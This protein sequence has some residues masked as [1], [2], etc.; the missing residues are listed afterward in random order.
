MKWLEG[1]DNFKAEQHVPIESGEA[2]SHC[3]NWSGNLWHSGRRVWYH[4]YRKISIIL[5]LEESAVHEERFTSTERMHH[6]RLV[7]VWKLYT[8]PSV[9]SAGKIPGAIRQSVLLRIWPAGIVMSVRNHCDTFRGS[10]LGYS[11]STQIGS[12]SDGHFK[13]LWT[14]GHLRAFINRWFSRSDTPLQLM[15]VI[16]Q[17]T[18]A[19]M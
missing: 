18:L 13:T 10:T 17:V 19:V 14:Y 3:S 4:D 11:T 2:T 8:I 16:R 5:I 7:Q 6:P 12:E 15:R 1:I 9:L